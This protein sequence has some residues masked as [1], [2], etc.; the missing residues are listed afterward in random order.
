VHFISH[1]H[2]NCYNNFNNWEKLGTKPEPTPNQTYVVT[3]YY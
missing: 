3:L 2:T 1:V